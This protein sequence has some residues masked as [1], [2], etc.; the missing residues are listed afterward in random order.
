MTTEHPPRRAGDLTNEQLEL[1]ITKAVEIQNESREI[2]EMA[3]KYAKAGGRDWE[4]YER[5]CDHLARKGS[6]LI[7]VGRGALSPEMTARAQAEIAE[8]AGTTGATSG[9]REHLQQTIAYALLTQ[10]Y[11]LGQ[12]YHVEADDWPD[13]L[14]AVVLGAVRTAPGVNDDPMMANLRDTGRGG[15]S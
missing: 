6:D 14:P 7:H 4:T 3:I 2:I 9:M 1:L 5:I 13:H 11:Y 15:E 12:H 8:A 10:V